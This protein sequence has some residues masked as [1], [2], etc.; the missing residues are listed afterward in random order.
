VEAIVLGVA[1]VVGVRAHK[2]LVVHERDVL[3]VDRPAGVGVEG[4][5]VVVLV[6]APGSLVHVVGVALQVKGG[7][8]GL[9]EDLPGGDGFRKG[10]PAVGHPRRSQLGQHGL[11]RLFH[12]RVQG[13]ILLKDAQRPVPVLHRVAP[14]HGQDVVRPERDDGD[15]AVVVHFLQKPFQVGQQVG[16]QP[17]HQAVGPKVGGGGPVDVEPEADG[18]GAWW[19]MESKKKKGDGGV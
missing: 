14:P 19:G 10:R 6:V 4:R 16:R 13:G 12:V 1:L 8:L 11:Q 5:R 9:V 18:V 7:F 15:Q 17:G 2:T 3:V